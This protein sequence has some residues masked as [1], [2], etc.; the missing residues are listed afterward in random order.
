[1]IATLLLAAVAPVT[2][3]DAERAFVIEAQKSG[4]W[5]AFRKFS[6]EDALMFVPQ[7][8]NAQ[9]F[10]K[11]LKDPPLSVYWWPGASFVSCDGGFAVN[12]GPWVREAGKSVGYFTTV[13]RRGGEDWRWIYDGGDGLKKPRAQGG[14]IRPDIASCSGKPKGAVVLGT[15]QSAGY[16]SGGGKSVDG[17]LVWSW[18][19]G[20][21]GDRHFLAQLWNG[22]QFRTVVDDQVAA[23]SE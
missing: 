3:I 21:K 16:R 22:K 19:V 6:A 12:T 15:V 14:D 11:D 5:T 23:P 20:P 17:T 18:T 4:Q 7:P 9:T 8:I 13:W 10:L 2:A 1:M